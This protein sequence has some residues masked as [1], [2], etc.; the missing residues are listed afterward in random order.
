MTVIV[1]YRLSVQVVQSDHPVVKTV[2]NVKI[3]NILRGKKEKKTHVRLMRDGILT[4]V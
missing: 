1:T 2:F 4:Y 3:G